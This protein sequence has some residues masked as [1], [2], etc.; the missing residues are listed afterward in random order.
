MV[1]ASLACL[2]PFNRKVQKLWLLHRLFLA[3]ATIEPYSMRHG[4][5]MVTGSARTE[6]TAGI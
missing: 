2:L 1:R 5:I 6:Y 4:S 3:E